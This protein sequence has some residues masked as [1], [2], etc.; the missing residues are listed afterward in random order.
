MGCIRY[1]ILAETPGTVPADSGTGC[2]AVYVAN[3]LDE[4][5]LDPALNSPESATTSHPVAAAVKA[6]NRADRR[7]RLTRA[8]RVVGVAGLRCRL[9]VACCT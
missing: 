6:Q 4:H 9:R 8:Y 5:A 1:E 2:S 7:D 3:G